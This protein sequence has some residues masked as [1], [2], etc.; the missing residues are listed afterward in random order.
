MNENGAEVSAEKKSVSV[1]ICV[2]AYIADERHQRLFERTIESILGL[3]TTNNMI[4]TI[5]VIDNASPRPVNTILSGR[6]A[7]LIQI[8][9]RDVNNIGAARTQAVSIAHEKHH[10]WIAF[11]D[12]DVEVPIEWLMVLDAELR[13]KPMRDAIGIATVNRPPHE[14]DFSRALDFFLGFEPLQ[15]GANQTLQLPAASN[16]NI[17]KRKVAHLSTCAVLLH[18][19][20][21][22]LVGGFD[23]SFSRVGED[24][25]LGY[26]LKAKGSLWLMSAPIVLH[27][28]DRNSKDWMRRM[29]RC[30][31]AQIDVARKYPEHLQS[32]RALPLLVGFAIV[33]SL[34]MLIVF[35]ISAP[36]K[37]LLIAYL[38]FVCA[39]MILRGISEGTMDIA[40]HACWIALVTH[41]GYAAGMWSGLLR[42]S[43]NPALIQPG[44][45]K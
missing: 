10:D 3:D 32:K 36:A 14:G 28:Q 37:L 1:L 39:P 42:I 13:T 43:R 30:G 44:D 20:T 29:F 19:K 40:F 9:R 12:S 24:A 4:A 31:W 11:I 2:V 5:M 16:Q 27:R 26:R 23:P 41:L 17:S 7:S 45:E 15:T 6:A 8:V 18:T 22:Y 38:G 25:E 21:L 35:G 34:L 33:A